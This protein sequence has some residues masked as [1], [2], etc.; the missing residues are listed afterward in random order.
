[1][2]QYIAD[3]K[4]STVVTCENYKT[5]AQQPMVSVTFEDGTSEI[6]P[7]KRLEATSTEAL[8]DASAV[9]QTLA[10]KT[11]AMLFSVLHEFGIKM[12][13]V[14]MIANSMVELAN[15]GYEAARDIMFKVPHRLLALNSINDILVNNAKTTGAAAEASDTDGASSNGSGSDSADTQ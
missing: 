5:P 3:K 9:Q 7:L 2:E 6:M 15:N 13:E 14:D 10:M 4:I 8:S 12:G 1:M 11:S